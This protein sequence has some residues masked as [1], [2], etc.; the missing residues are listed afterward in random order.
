MISIVVTLYNEAGSLDELY[1]RTAKTLEELGSPWEL[2]FVDD[3]STDGAFG[4]LERL[5]AADPRVRAVRFRRNFGQHPAVHGLDDIVDDVDR[6][7]QRPP[8]RAGRTFLCSSLRSTPAPT[9]QTIDTASPAPTR[10]DGRSL[11]ADQ[12]HAA[13]VRRRRH[14]R[15]RLRIP[16]HIAARRFE[17]ML[18]AIGEQGL[19]KARSFFSGGANVTEVDVRHAPPKSPSRYSPLRLVRLRAPRVGSP[20][21]RAGPIQSISVAFGIVCSL[22]AT[23]LGVYAVVY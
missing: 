8:T 7:D 20:A 21:S 17:P 14:L 5:H 11:E 15:L 18:P 3:G 1:G 19:T 12:R 4:E 23:A 10:R 2:I 13:Q 9:W 6:I 16:T 22:V